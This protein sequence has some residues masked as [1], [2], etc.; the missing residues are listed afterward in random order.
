MDSKM[1]THAVATANNIS[2]TE[3]PVYFLTNLQ[4]LGDPRTWDYLVVMNPLFVFPLV[5]LYIYFVKVTGPRWMKDR[6]PYRIDGL[7]RAYNLLIVLANLKLNSLLLTSMYLPGG[8]YSLWCQGITGY[9]DDRLD[10]VYRTG[11]V[12]VI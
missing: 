8:S 7:V 3:N 1:S 2:F 11:W 9:V 5:L 12:N 6:Q 10:E 4:Q